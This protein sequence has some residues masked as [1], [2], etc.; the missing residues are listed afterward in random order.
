[1]QVHGKRLIY[2]FYYGTLNPLA[3]ILCF[4][5]GITVSLAVSPPWV[6]VMSAAMTLLCLTGV[7]LTHRWFQRGV[8]LSSLLLLAAL[9]FLGLFTGSVRLRLLD[10][11]FLT[12]LDGKRISTQ[13]TVN[14]PVI[15]K[16]QKLRFTGEVDQARWQGQSAEPG[17]AAL[18]E[19]SCRQACPVALTTMEEGS[20]ISAEAL[21]GRPASAP[22][23]DF[24]YGAYLRRR[25]VHAVLQADASRTEV[26]PEARDGPS[27]VVDAL[28]RH[29]RGSLAAGDWGSAG[30]LLKGMVLGDDQGVPESVI[31]DFR[32]AG[33]LH[34]LA[35]SGQNVALLGFIILLLLRAVQVPKLAAIII[36]IGVIAIYVPLAGA[37][38]SIVRAGVVGILG[39]AAMIFSR[40]ADR[41][42]FLALSAAVILAI[43]PYSLLDPGFQ[44]SYAAV[45]AIFFV[46][47]VFEDLLNILLPR[48][49]GLLA[50]GLAIS[51]ATGLATAPITLTDFGQISLVTVPANLAA[52][53]VAGPVMMVG[54]LAILAQ[55]LLPLLSWTLVTGGCLCTGFL[56]V[57]ARLMASLP[58]AVY[59]GSAPSWLAT[60]VFYAML[61]G[62]VVAA[63][64]M[65]VAETLA[66]LRA[67]R[68]LLVPL[69]LLLVLLIGVA[70]AVGG[71]ATGTPP[72]N[73]RVSFLDIGQGDATVIQVPP[74]DQSPE[75]TTVLIDGGPGSG[76]VDRLRESGVTRL[77]AVFL[78]HP[79][80]DHVAGLIDV[81]EQFPVAAVF[82][83][84]P[85]SSSQIYL[86]FLKT[87]EQKAIPYS[88]TRKGRTIVYGEL[89]LDVLS[90]GDD[91]KADDL[92]AD[93]LVILAR[94]GGLDI[95]IPGD[96]EGETLAGLDLPRV[97]VYK[98]PHHGS[99]DG[100]INRVLDKLK[101][102]AAII[103]V[104]EGNPYGHPTDS[105]MSALEKAGISIYRTDRQGTVSVSLTGGVMEIATRK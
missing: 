75:G 29:S 92:N 80:A 28:R 22:G 23:A 50:Q 99:R 77:D 65:G 104:G 85:P 66:R 27:G 101:P 24:D 45:L 10:Q 88:I 90:P 46:A 100:T 79:H 54:V 4:I 95:L 82:D 11:S 67:G 33:L 17:E 15:Q 76:V 14:S 81:L 96:A 105:T 58:G 53:P 57:L 98:V 60:S 18:I 97:A 5:A 64:K 56:I 73:Y 68:G 35:V 87:V 70:C 38:P 47:P 20:R 63:R 1:M 42:H 7:M 9:L 62:I 69:A 16:D 21:V 51:T 31:N 102:R 3:K 32:D 44:L 30:E 72:A 2:F 83:A 12:Q 26:L 52:E 61:I 94:F 25:G 84:A 19:I 86:D 36:A 91:L 8:Y 89:E 48:M 34:M 74:T 6:C 49:P 59:H 55:P 37:G 78:T 13:I 103:S 41:Y 93:S 43:N 39:M 71:T 40:Q